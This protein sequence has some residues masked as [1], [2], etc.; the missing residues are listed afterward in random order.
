MKIRFII[1]LIAL[2]TL[3]SCLINPSNEDDLPDVSG[4]IY[5]KGVIQV[6]TEVTLKNQTQTWTKDTDTSGYFLFKDVNKDNYDL[7]VTKSF[8]DSSYIS[9]T[10]HIS[11]QQD[12]HLDHFRIPKPVN[13][14]DPINI[15]NNSI[16]LNWSRYSEDDFYEYKLYR[17]YN[18]V[19]DNE[20]GDLIKIST[21][22]NDTT[23][24]DDGSDMPY[25]L[26]EDRT[27]YYRIYVNNEYANLGGSSILEVKTN[28]FDIDPDLLREYDLIEK[29]N[30]PNTFPGTLSGIDFDGEYLW[31]LTVQYTGEYYDPDTVNLIKYDLSTGNI[32]S[33]FKY[34]NDYCGDRMSLAWGNEYLWL[35]NEALNKIMKIDSDEGQILTSFSN[36]YGVM[37]MTVYNNFLYLCYYYGIIQKINTVNLNIVN[38]WQNPFGGGANNGIAARNNEIWLSDY[39]NKNLFIL[40]N[41]GQHIG[42]AYNEILEDFTGYKSNLNIC[43]MNEDLVLCKN[44]RIY[45]CEIQRR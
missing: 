31:F 1:C 6:S 18:S 11:I 21:N 38:T 14:H 36:Q 3:T 35:S 23:F 17:G 2:T 20:T 13:F 40:N 45:I 42:V 28:L 39:S 16:T 34:Y 10:E 26:S 8:D 25:G 5:Y 41:Q 24:S 12:I 44:G 7:I 33:H 9:K 4:Y 32:I 30:F 37:G 19:L 22:V 15:T 27:Y 29:Q 43:F